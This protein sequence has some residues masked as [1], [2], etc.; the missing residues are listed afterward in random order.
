LFRDDFVPARGAAIEEGLGAG[1]EPARAARVPAAQPRR[2]RTLPIPLPILGAVAGVI[3]LLVVVGVVLRGGVFSDGEDAVTR[4]LT[5]AQQLSQQGRLQEAITML[6][7]VQ[8]QSE[9][10]QASQLSQRLLEYQRQL[11]AKSAPTQ[12]VDVEAIKQA[13]AAGQRIKALRLIR[14]ALGLAPG[15]P[16]LL[17]Q[18]AVIVEYARNLPQLADA[19]SSRRWETVRTVA[20]EIL[21]QHPDDPEVNRLWANATFNLA[22]TQL[23][24]YQVAAAHT[25]LGELAEATGDEEAAQHQRFAAAYLSRPTDPRYNIYVGNIELRIAD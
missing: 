14:E 20:A 13:I 22:V 18:Q 7:S 4:A 5:E 3:A 19:Q 1:L 24:K 21:K 6:Q 9:G 11:K 8:D 17:A 16:A 23:R 2:R 10:E 15:E 25:L 12:A